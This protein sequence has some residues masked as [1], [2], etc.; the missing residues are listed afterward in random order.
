MKIFNFKFLNDWRAKFYYIP[1]TYSIYAL[2]L[3]VVVLILEKNYQSYLIRILPA[4]FFTSFEI[5]KTI[6]S[7]IAGSL[8]S[9]VTISFSI[10]M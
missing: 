6:L 9:I 3:A 5:T 2:L 4:L 8:L 1:V 7:T 10:I